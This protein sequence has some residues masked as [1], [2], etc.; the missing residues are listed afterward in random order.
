MSAQPID[1]IDHSFFASLAELVDLDAEGRA[2]RAYAACREH[3]EVDFFPGQG[4]ATREAKA[5]C[6]GCP[7]REP[8]LAAAMRNGE[9]HGIWGGLSER[10]RR[11]Q[12]RSTRPDLAAAVLGYLA[13]NGPHHGSLTPIADAIGS[14]DTNVGNVVRR[15]EERGAITV[16]P[17]MPRDLG[18]R[19]RTITIK[20]QP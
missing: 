6:A 7:V 1:P 16:D 5:I 14:V 17:P 8:C 9:K 3:P 10:E 19:I 20:E 4:E 11:R 15:L 18:D 13:A 2:W 12:R